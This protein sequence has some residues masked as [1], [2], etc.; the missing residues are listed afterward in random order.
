[1]NYNE[2]IARFMRQKRK[3]KVRAN[4]IRNYFAVAKA[5]KLSTNSIL[6]AVR[7]GNLTKSNMS[8]TLSNMRNLV[9]QNVQGNRNNNNNRY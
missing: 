9:K 5:L 1:M 2:Y 8:Q 4:P 6:I 7:R 3:S